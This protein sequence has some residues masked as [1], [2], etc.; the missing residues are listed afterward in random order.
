[1]PAIPPESW[2]RAKAA[3]RGAYVVIHPGTGDPRKAWPTERWSQ[4]I[5]RLGGAGERV[6]ITGRGDAEG[7]IAADLQAM[8]PSVVNT[9]GRLD[10]SAFRALVANATLLI[11]PDSAAAHVAA[12]DGV[13]TIAIMAAMS[14]PEYWRPLGSDVVALTRPVPCAPC[15]RKAGCPAMTCVRDVSVDEVFSAYERLRE[16]HRRYASVEQGD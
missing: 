3:V 1:M 4:L 16:T 14:D 5:A 11:G 10:W 8:H 15:F 2:E 9:C 13:P 7:R 6:V 12:A